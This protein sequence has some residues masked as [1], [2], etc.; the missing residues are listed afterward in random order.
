MGLIIAFIVLSVA[1]I[2]AATM[3]GLR[4][5]SRVTPEDDLADVYFDEEEDDE[6]EGIFDPSNLR[7]PSDLNNFYDYDVDDQ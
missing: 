1:A 3:Y 4:R 2:F 5:T 6:W 7:K